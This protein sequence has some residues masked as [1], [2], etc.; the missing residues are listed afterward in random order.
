MTWNLDVLLTCVD[1][2]NLLG[3]MWSEVQK[4]STPHFTKY[5]CVTPETENSTVLVD[6]RPGVRVLNTRKN[7]LTR[8]PCRLQTHFYTNVVTILGIVHGR[9]NSTWGTVT[10]WTSLELRTRV[11]SNVS[12]STSG[13]RTRKQRSICLK[14]LYSPVLSIVWMKPP[15]L[16]NCELLITCL[17]KKS[18]HKVHRTG[19]TAF[20]RNMIMH[21]K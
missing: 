3:T 20:T 19:R 13:I 12:V 7:R 18:R 4:T 10:R 5:Y 6:S 21:G 11:V 14:S 9:N 15:R 2:H 8:L 17:P 16:M 1:L